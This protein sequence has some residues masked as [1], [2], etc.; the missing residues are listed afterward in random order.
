MTGFMCSGVLSCKLGTE[1]SVSTKGV[2]FLNQLR[3]FDDDQEGFRPTY[4][5]T[6]RIFSTSRRSVR[7]LCGQSDSFSVSYTFDGIQA[8]E[9]KTNVVNIFVMTPI[10]IS[11][12]TVAK[13]DHTLEPITVI[14]LAVPS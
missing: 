13:A 5:V 14:S 1:S 3:D 10:Q 6:I 7:I 11:P 2:Q 12:G 8:N 4:C 9:T